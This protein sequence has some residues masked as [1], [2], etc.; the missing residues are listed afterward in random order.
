MY[1]Y[2]EIAIVFNVTTFY[3]VIKKMI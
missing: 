3:V 2:E 1:M